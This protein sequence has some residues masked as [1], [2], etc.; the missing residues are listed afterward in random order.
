[1]IAVAEGRDGD[2]A[3]T[4]SSSASWPA[5]GL[6]STKSSEDLVDNGQA[7]A[8]RLSP[9]RMLRARNGTG[10]VKSCQARR[11]QPGNKKPRLAEPVGWVCRP[12]RPRQPAGLVRPAQLLDHRREEGCPASEVRIVTGLADRLLNELRALSRRCASP[13][14]E[15][16]AHGQMRTVATND[17]L[18]CLG[19]SRRLIASHSTVSP[20]PGIGSRW[21]AGSLTSVGLQEC[22]E[23]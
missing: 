20:R 16:V 15:K 14:I 2:I 11:G 9:P 23:R 18:E 17:P 10:V 21:S 4:R 22:I 6:R 19:S 13:V 8:S 12:L 5:S 7:R 1:M 3:R